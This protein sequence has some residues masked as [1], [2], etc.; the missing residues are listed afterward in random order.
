[1][2]S[3]LNLRDHGD[4]HALNQGIFYASVIDEPFD[5]VVQAAGMARG[6]PVYLCGFSLGGNF[7]LRMARLWPRFGPSEI[8][9]RHIVAVSPVLDPSRATDAVDSHRL[10]RAYFLRKWRRSLIRKQ[11]LYPDLYDFTPLLEQ[12]TVRGMTEALL[13]YGGLYES[14]AAYFAEYTL[15]GSALADAG[16]NTTLITAA[17]DPI[18]PVDDFHSLAPNPHIRCIIHSR[19]GHNGFLTGRGWRRWHETYMLSAFTSRETS[20]VVP[21]TVQT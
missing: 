13:K 4:S 14:T 21:D 1:M 10:I 19:G 5:A 12:R 11:Q 6:V 18:I 2:S 9:L 20:A 3:R 15:C 8:D 7:V 16:T 17:D